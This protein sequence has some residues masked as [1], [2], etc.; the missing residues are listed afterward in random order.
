VKGNLAT[1]SFD[2]VELDDEERIVLDEKEKGD[3]GVAETGVD[4]VHDDAGV[5]TGDESES[6]G[7]ARAA[8]SEVRMNA[9]AGSKLHISHRSS[10]ATVKP[11]AGSVLPT[12]AAPCP[13]TAFD[14]PCERGILL[15]PT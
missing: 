13:E 6:T 14:L 11:S 8:N 2:P 12:T 10:V 7:D 4:L 5:D 3:E 15:I 9:I 1:Y